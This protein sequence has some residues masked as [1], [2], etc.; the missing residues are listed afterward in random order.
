MGRLAASVY[1]TGEYIAIERNCTATSP[2]G[3]EHIYLEI[4]R[5]DS[6][7]LYSLCTSVTHSY[8]YTSSPQ[9]NTRFPI[10]QSLNWLHQI[11]FS[12]RVSVFPPFPPLLSPHYPTYTSSHPSNHPS[13]AFVFNI[14]PC[15]PLIIPPNASLTNLCCLSILSPLNL[16]LTTSIEYMVPQPPETSFTYI[17][18]ISPIL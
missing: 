15:H 4:L 8:V 18:P 2:R 17:T 5:E 9:Y 10:P 7:P 6:Y 12:L 3:A 13:G 11:P 16:S 1:L 14:T